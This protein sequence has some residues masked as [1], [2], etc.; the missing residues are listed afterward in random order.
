MKQTHMDEAH[1]VPGGI[2]WCCS[3]GCAAMP[4][5]AQVQRVIFASAGF[6]ETQPLLDPQSPQSAPE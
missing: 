6:D 4:A 5:E 3:W 2:L 1:D